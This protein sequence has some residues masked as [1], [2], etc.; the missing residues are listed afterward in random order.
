MMRVQDI[1]LG[2]SSV[3][4]RLPDLKDVSMKKQGNRQPDKQIAELEYLEG[5]SEDQ[6]NLEDIPEM[7]DWSGA[8]RGLLL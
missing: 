6:I 8:R 1:N 5:L 2:E 3:F 4:E 7:T